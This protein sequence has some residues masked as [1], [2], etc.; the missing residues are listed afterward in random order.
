MALSGRRCA[1]LGGKAGRGSVSAIS[2][3]TVFSINRPLLAPRSTAVNT[4]AGRPRRPRRRR[5]R[6]P[7]RD[8][9]MS[10]ALVAMA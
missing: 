7:Q 10:L 2:P 6:Q 8:R 5:D 3:S 9:V 4:N 1:D